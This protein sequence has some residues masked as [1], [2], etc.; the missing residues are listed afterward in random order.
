MLENFVNIIIFVDREKKEQGVFLPL[1]FCAAPRRSGKTGT[2]RLHRR[3]GEARPNE[4]DY[5]GRVVRLPQGLG[6]SI[7]EKQATKA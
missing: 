7:S 4:E 5:S 3:T 6:E 2:E 1:C